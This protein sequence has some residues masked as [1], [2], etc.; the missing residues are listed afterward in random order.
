MET[1]SL[2]IK[3]DSALGSGDKILLYFFTDQENGAQLG[4]II[5]DTYAGGLGLSFDSTYKYWLT[6]CTVSGYPVN[7]E[8]DVVPT[9]VNKLFLMKI[10]LMTLKDAITLLV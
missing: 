8:A 5:E 6:K 1:T 3:T 9:E 2:Q 7:F 10:I 4:K